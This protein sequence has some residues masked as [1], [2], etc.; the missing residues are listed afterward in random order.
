MSS[1]IS[2][3]TPTPSSSTPSSE[4]GKR[5]FFPKIDVAKFSPIALAGQTGVELE[6]FGSDGNNVTLDN[7]CL[8]ALN[9]PVQT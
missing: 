6:D 1:Y 7:E 5:S 9:W 4:L 2:S 3:L 8:V